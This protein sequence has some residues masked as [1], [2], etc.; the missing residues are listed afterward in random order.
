LSGRTMHEYS[1]NR[2]T[3]IQLDVSGYKPGV[4]FLKITNEH[5]NQI[6]KLIKH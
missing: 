1:K 2:D 4:Y 6:F 5:S 3:S